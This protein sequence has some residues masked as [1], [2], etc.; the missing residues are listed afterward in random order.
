MTNE[1]KEEDAKRRG[2]EDEEFPDDPETLEGCMDILKD[3][4]VKATQ[5]HNEV[6]E[7]EKG[8]KNFSTMPSQISSTDNEI[9]DDANGKLRLVK[10]LTGS[11]PAYRV[12][13]NR[14]SVY[15][16]PVT[17]LVRACL[18]S[19][20]AGR[21]KCKAAAWNKSKKTCHKKNAGCWGSKVALKLW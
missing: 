19:A 5:C 9:G 10:Y 12:H 16:S 20:A 14:R 21:T 1:V 18:E 4:Q 7:Y 15:D 17:N 3:C 2:T 8:N 11:Y 13:C 6:A